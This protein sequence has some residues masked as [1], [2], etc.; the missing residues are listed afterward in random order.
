MLRSSLAIGMGLAASIAAGLLVAE[1]SANIVTTRKISNIRIA[2][3]FFLHRRD[4][5]HHHASITSHVLVN[6]K[7]FGTKLFLIFAYMVL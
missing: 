2:C 1:A 3:Y 7:S 6:S 4:A 5:M